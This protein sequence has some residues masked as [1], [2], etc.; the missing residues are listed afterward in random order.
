MNPS[1][2]QYA[3]SRLDAARPLRSFSAGNR[4]KG[5]MFRW[6]RN[7]WR[8]IATV[9]ASIVVG[10]AVTALVIATAP[11]SVPA[12]VVTGGALA[13]GGFAAGVTGYTV[14]RWL[15]GRP[16]ELGALLYEGAVGAIVS[17]ATLGLGRALA[18]AISRAV[19]PAVSRT[20]PN[21]AA[22]FVTRAATET[23]SFAAAGATTGA[24]TQVVSNAL[25]GRPL[26]EN[27]DRAARDGAIVN[28]TLAL[29]ARAAPALL[30]RRT[31]AAR[32]VDPVTQSVMDRYGMTR[33]TI[34]YRV[35]NPRYVQ[36][37]T[38]TGNPNSV[39]RVRDP[40]NLVENPQYPQAPQYLPRFVDRELFAREL[41]RPSLNV[42]LRDPVLYA[43]P[44]TV[45]VGIRLGDLL[46]RG[47]RIY[48][49]VGAVGQGARPLVVTFD[50]AVPVTVLESVA[51]AEAVSAGAPSRTGGFLG[52]LGGAG[53]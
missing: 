29:A 44:G 7:N 51:A 42:A 33:D 45:R 34:V 12:L 41:G 47:G 10:V 23:G 35:T 40:Y 14:N 6:L 13:A 21:A 1:S 27:V 26:L 28:G 36:D 19:A 8:T 18:P 30:P 50:G 37:G 9:A 46:D 24:G 32:P 49:D 25:A 53:R 3:V 15:H 22:P 17:V 2:A 31:T 43:E 38:I 20:V 52:A 5:T 4:E 11:V 48:P 39:A 16:I